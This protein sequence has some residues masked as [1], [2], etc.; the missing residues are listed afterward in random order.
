MRQR[1]A[2]TLLC[3]MRRAV[4]IALVVVVVVTGLPVF[5]GMNGMAFCADCG[6]GLLGPMTCLAALAAAGFALPLLLSRRAG[7]TRY[8]ALRSRLLAHLLERPPQLVTA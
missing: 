3:S 4:V 8:R 1:P 7:A 2:A 5:M 6:P